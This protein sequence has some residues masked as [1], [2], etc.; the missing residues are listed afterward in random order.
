MS[1]FKDTLEA[2]N[3]GLAEAETLSEYC[4]VKFGQFSPKFLPVRNA[5]EEIAQTV[6]IL[7]GK[8]APEEVV[9]PDAGVE[10]EVKAARQRPEKLAA[11]PEPEPEP[12]MPFDSDADSYGSDS[13]PEVSFS[14]EISSVDDATRALVFRAA[15][16]F[17]ARIPKTLRPI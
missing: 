15:H 2:L 5:I 6:K 8:K 17:A 14:G 13:T 16:F 12:E 4:D 3:E 1:F 10:L 9:L 11:E 7:I